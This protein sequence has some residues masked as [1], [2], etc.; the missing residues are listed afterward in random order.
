ML[1]NVEHV[2]GT[3]YDDIFKGMRRIILLPE[4]Q[5][6]IRTYLCRV[7]VPISQQRAA[8]LIKFLFG[9]MLPC[10]IYLL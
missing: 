3:D 10:R 8:D 1:F 7:A 2:V 5:A 6:M 9:A 4:A